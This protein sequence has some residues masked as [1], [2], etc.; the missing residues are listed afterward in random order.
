[1][2][3]FGNKNNVDNQESLG[4]MISDNATD[5]IK[6]LSGKDT[7]FN[8]KLIDNIVVF[9]GAA[10]GTGTS[11]LVSNV[12]YMAS[13]KDLNVL[14]IDLNIMYPVQ[15]NTFRCKQD[16]NKP[17]LTS[18]LYGKSSLGESIEIIDNIGIM[19]AKSGT[20]VDM[21]NCEDTNAVKNLEE[22]IERVKQLYDLVIV[23]CP[24]KI[25]SVLVNSIL[26]N[27][28]HIY[29]VWD[30]GISSLA[31]TDRIRKNME[32]SGISSRNKVS[33]ILNKRT[34]IQ[35]TFYAFDRLGIELEQVIP[36]DVNVID[37]GLMAQVFCDKG[38]YRGTNSVEFYRSIEELT[39][40]VLENGGYIG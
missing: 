38:A 10:G 27:S 33:V 37:N 25:E 29:L 30:E 36:F 2:G 6:R 12:A 23:D 1:M 20:I 26:Y 14:V 34:S 16:I 13:K 18:Y 22:M 32:L 39:D 19:V 40:K 21:V 7:K 24:N 4:K 9:T 3:L 11:T 35:Y 5:I 8:K 15:H 28:N 31:N 17:D